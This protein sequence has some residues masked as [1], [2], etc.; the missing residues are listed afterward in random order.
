[1]NENKEVYLG[2]G[3]Y[4][5]EDRGTIKLRAPMWDEGRNEVIYLEKEV[6][7]ALVRYANSV[8]KW[9]LANE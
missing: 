7:I 9:K 2:D 5:S 8:M 6:F 4:A 3:L 1:M